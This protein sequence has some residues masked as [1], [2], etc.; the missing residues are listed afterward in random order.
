MKPAEREDY[1]YSKGKTTK[2]AIEE[3]LLFDAIQNYPFPFL[4][5]CGCGLWHG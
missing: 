5:Y 4:P 1:L 3:R 2:I